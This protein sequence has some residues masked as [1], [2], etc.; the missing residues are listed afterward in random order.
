MSVP[1][2]ADRAV[3][4]NRRPRRASLLAS[5]SVA[6]L[7]TA[8]VPAQARDILRGNR[9]AAPVAAVTAQ[10]AAA[11]QQAR[12][13]SNALQRT[14]QAVQ[15]MR[16]A[17]NAARNLALRT[18]AAVPNG[19]TPDGLV[20]ALGAGAVPG[21][22]TGARLPTQ[23]QVDGRTQV[24]IKQTE[25]KAILNWTTFNV[26]RET[27]VRFDQ[28]GNSTW[29]ALN[30]VSDPA[31]RPSRIAGQIKA[32]GHVYI[33]NRNGVIFTGS[34][35]VNTHALIASSAG[36]TD[37]Q[38]RTAGIYSAQAA[39]AYVPS[40]RGAAGLVR[41][42]AGAEITTHTPTS[43]TSGG[44]FV[45]L[46]GIGVENA[47][48]IAT[49]KG[50]ALLAAG[51]DFILRRGYGTDANQSS[52]TR[53]SEVAPIIG[54]GSTSGT[55]VNAGL[56]FS[57]QGDITLVGRSVTQAG[58]ALATTSVNTRGTIHLLNAASDTQGSVVLATGSL[59]AILPELDSVETALDSQRSALIT[60]S[61]ASAHQPVAHAQFTNLSLLPDRLDQSRVEIVSG[62][63]VVFQRG[64]ITQAQGGQV[65]VSAARRV[66]AVDGALIDVSGTRDVLLPMSSNN[67]K[68]SIQGNELRDAPINRDSGHL[69]SSDVWIDTR[70]L[71]LVPAGTGG[72]ASER[73]Y[74]R[75]GLLEVRGYLNN[76]GHR[77]GEW[78]ALGGTIALSAREVVAQQG[79]IFDVSGGAV[80]YDGGYIRTTNLLG[81]DGRVYSVNGAPADQLFYG[82]GQGFVRKH[83]RWGVTEIWMN[84]LGKGRESLRWEAGYTIG[85]DAGGLILSA[86]TTIFD[87]TIVA[88]V[89][90]G[91][92]QA[93]ARP[94]GVTDGY[95]L[96]Q[97]TAPRAGSLTVGRYG[98]LGVEGGH[99]SKIVVGAVAPLVSAIGAATPLPSARTN[100]VLL[101]ARRLNDSA[102][103]GL[104]LT[105]TQ[106]V[107]IDA[108]L[109]LADGGSL[110]ITA[111]VTTIGADITAHSGRVSI[112]NILKVP[113]R[114]PGE[115]TPQALT[116]DGA[117]GVTLKAGTA[118][119]VRGVWT[120]AVLDPT[121]RIG[122]AYVD[123][124]T[125]SVATTGSVTIER[126]SLID[127]SSGAAWLE[128]GKLLG[129]RGGDVTLQVGVP[130][131]DVITG[132][133]L[134]LDG[135]LR[136]AGVAGGGTLSLQSP[137]TVLIGKDAVLAGGVLRANERA[138]TGVV[139]AQDLAI[140]PGG[141]I[142]VTVTEMRSTTPLE[143][144]LPA[145]TTPTNQEV[146]VT[147]STWT[148][149]PGVM[150]ATS[151][152]RYYGAGAVLPAGTR[153]AAF[154]GGLPFGMVVPAAVFPRGIPVRPFQFTLV[155]GSRTYEGYTYRPGQKVPQGTAFT[156][157]VRFA[158]PFAVD[159]GLFQTGFSTYSLTSLTGL[160]IGDGARID[161]AM[162]VLRATDTAFAAPT[163]STPAQVLAQWL[164]P[165][166]RDDPVTGRLTQRA[167]ANLILAGMDLRVDRGAAVTVD[168]GRSVR[169][170]TIR[171]ITVDGA[172]VAPGG[173]VTIVNDKVFN[174]EPGMNAPGQSI[175][176]GATA[177]LDVSAQAVTARDANGR[178]YGIVTEGG[179]IRIGIDSGQRPT[180][181]L[182]IIRDGA[183][184]DAS[185]TAVDL[186][187]PAGR[188]DAGASVTRAS[189][190]GT[191][192]IGSSAGLLLD[193][194]MRAAAG[195]QGAAGG[196]LEL[197]LET[198]YVS[199]TF[200]GAARGPHV[201]TITQER[202]GRTQPDGLVAGVHDPALPYGQ[203]R[204]SVEQ[205]RAGGFD[206]LSLW[207]RDI[208]R[209]DGD[210]DLAMGRS[211]ILQRGILSVAP[212]TPAARVS[213][214]APH[215]VLAGQGNIELPDDPT[216]YYA[217]IT[218]TGYG[219]LM[220][221][222]NAG[223]L[224]V[225]ADLIDLR[226]AV[227]FGALAQHGI[228]PVHN[229]PIDLPG[230]AD[231]ALISRG[232]VRIGNGSVDAGRRLT[233]TAAQLYPTTGAKATIRA[234][235]YK[236]D[237]VYDI[238]FDPNAVI[239]IRGLGDAPPP[240][241]AS[242]FGSLQLMAATMEQGGI[243]R[244]PLGTIVL[245]EGVSKADPR[246]A[247]QMAATLL[248]GSV[249][250][251]SAAGL[252][253]PYGG[254]VDGL[255]YTY[256]GEKVAFSDL[257]ALVGDNGVNQGITLGVGRIDIDR[258]ALLD[259][260][261]GGELSGAAFFTGRGGS[262][263]VLRT[264]LAN[265]N[266]A[267][268]RGSTPG[269]RVYAI[270]PG[271][272]SAYA[273]LA[274]ETGAGDPVVGQQVTL[275]R[276]VG[277]LP[278]GTYTLLPSTY[279]LLPGA[280][281]VEIGGAAP[282]DATAR[283]ADGSHVAAGVLSVANTA[284][285][286]VL[287]TLLTL[288][289][290]SIVRTHSQY[291]ETS[292][293]AF[294]LANAATFNAV[295]PRLPVDGK[296][297][298][299]SFGAA[300]GETLRF[301][302]QALF[303]PARGGYGGT[304][305]VIANTGIEVKAAGA[306]A[307]P[308]LVSL[309]AQDL[310]AF[311][312]SALLIGGVYRYEL[313]FD[314]STSTALGPRVI[315]NGN[316]AGVAVRQGA[317][318][319]GGQIFVVGRDIVI[320]RGATLD[321]SAGSSNGIDSSLGYVF[322][323]SLD[324]RNSQA[325]A[326]LTVANGYFHFLPPI[327]DARPSTIKVQDGAILRT[328][329]TIA[330]S[331]AGAVDP[332]QAALNAR[333]L[334][335][336]LPELNI[337]DAASFAA[338]EA[339]GA[340]GSGWR[341]TQSMIARLL[342]PTASGMTPVERLTFTVGGSINIFGGVT[343]DMRSTG[344]TRTAL[345]LN[346]PA[347][348]GWGRP[349]EVATIATDTLIWSGLVQGM[350]TVDK[351]YVSVGP[352]AVRP[353]G[354]GTGSGALVVDA[355]QIV[356]GYDPSARPQ[357]QATLDRLMLGF[358]AVS[359]QA[360]ERISANNRSSLA[361]YHT[362]ASA[363]TY[364]GGSLALRTPLLTGEAGSFMTYRSGGAVTVSA[365]AGAASVDTATITAL[366]GEVR[367]AGTRVTLDTAVALPSG[368]LMLEAASDIA[369]H[370]RAVIDLS[371]R[372]VRFFDVTRY[373]WGG[374]L[375]MES[376][377]GAIRQAAGSTI[378]VSARNND[379]GRIKVTATGADGSVALAGRL[380][381]AAD[382]GF[383]AGV[384]DIRARV[385]DDFA[386]L[387]GRL[388]QGEVFGA[389]SFVIKTGDLVVGDD[390]R[391]RRVTI[392]VD[393]GSLT[394]NG[395]IDASGRGAGII[396]LAARDNLVL[397]TG[398]MLDAHGTV[399]RVDS[400]GAPI[401][402]ANTAQIE[403]TTTHG[404]L[405][406]AR[407][408]VIDLRAADGVARGRLELNAPRTVAAG[409]DSDIAISAAGPL[410]IS[411]AASIAINGWRR[412]AADGGLVD[413]VLLDRI[414]GDSTTFIDAAR[415]NDALRARLAGLDAH[416]LHLRPGVEI[417]SASA[418][419]DL[420]I[421]GD[422][423][424][425]GYRYGPDADPA[426]RGSGEPGVVVIRAGGRL[427]VNGSINDGFAPPP[428]TPDD[429]GWADGR[430][431][432]I[433]AI[434][435]M[436][437]P[438]SLSWSMR[439]VAGADTASADTR[440][441]RPRSSLAGGGDLV[442]SDEH[443]SG[444]FPDRRVFSV[445][446]T[447]T[448]TLD[449]LAGGD[450]R[451]DSLFGVY[452]AGTAIA[453]G[454]EHNL[455]LAPGYDG[456]VLGYPDYEA[457]LSGTRMWFTTGGGDVLLSAQGRVSS[458][459]VS[460]IDMS[461]STHDIGDWLWRQGGAD[462]GQPTAWG[463]NFGS[464]VA[465]N[466]LGVIKVAG[467]A[468][469]GA[470]GGGNVTVEAGGDAGLINP[471]SRGGFDLFTDALNIA[472][473][474]SG[475]V[476][477]DGTLAQTGGGDL[478]L[479][480]GGRLNPTMVT[481]SLFQGLVTNV[482]G[483]IRVLA[484]SI[485][486]TELKQ[487]GVPRMDD[488]RPVDNQAPFV[489]N[490]YSGLAVAP[491][492][493]RATLSARGDL[494]MFIAADP[495][496]VTAR[497]APVASDGAQTAAGTSWFTLWTGTTAIDLFSAGGYVS[498]M[499]TF[500]GTFYPPNLSVV[501]AGGSI[502]FSPNMM[503][504]MPA[505]RGSLELLARDAIDGYGAV[506]TS[507]PSYISVSGGSPDDLAT[508]LRP[509]W[510]LVDSGGTV[511]ATNH[512]A[513]VNGPR[514]DSAGFYWYGGYY[515]NVAFV[516]G[517]FTA[518]AV[519][520][521]AGDPDPI[522]I[523]ALTGDISNLEIGNIR[524]DY[525]G[526]AY[527]ASYNA[528]KPVWLRAGRDILNLTALILNNDNDDISL[529]AAGRD[530]V[531][532]GINIAGPGLLEV[533]AG[534][535]IYQARGTINS[536]GPVITGD[537]RDGA[538]ITLLAG[539]GVNG[540]AYARFA[541][542]YL[543]PANRADPLRPLADQDGKVAKTYQ[544]E[545]VAWLAERFG[546]DGG[547]A[548]ALAYFQHLPV[549]QQAVFVR[550]VYFEELRQGGREYND[551]DSRRFGSYLRGRQAIATLL[552]DTDAAGARIDYSG[553][554]TLIGN[555]GVHT[556]FGGGIQAFTP[557]GG[558]LLGANGVAPPPSTGLLTQG[559]G[560]IEIYSRDSVLL[561]L[562]RI[563]TTFGGDIVI[564]SAVGDINAGRGAKTTVVYAPTKRVYDNYGNV[565]LSPQVPSTGAGI[566]TL[567][568]I[569]E[570]PAGD[571]DLIAPLGTID[572]GEAGIRVSG[573]I[574]LAALHILNAANIQVQGS[575]TGVPKAPPPNVGAMLS[576]ST[577][578]GAAAATTDPSRQARQAPRDLP[579]IITVE[580]LGY[581]GGQGGGDTQRRDDAPPRPGG[582]QQG[583]DAQGMFRV[584]GNGTFTGEQVRELTDEERRK[585]H[586]QVGQNAPL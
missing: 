183:R 318:L 330:F 25:A 559:S 261:G 223:H 13:A 411:G 575:I 376:T 271:Y 274:P 116:L 321:T 475:R 322:S 240:L 502:I 378:D 458:Y 300:K 345:I 418:G 562:S 124:G 580:V 582:S 134:T 79:A 347:L 153:I 104:H 451:Q 374:E 316:D 450:Y 466:L 83:A 109:T 467:F 498:P 86:P 40:F 296:T 536:I 441:L 323:D 436:L 182:V 429:H 19:L 233:I 235:V 201:F 370:D 579:S 379:A 527:V 555:A 5:V 497:G 287:P 506:T 69:K 130:A 291:N 78:A 35:Q 511:L 427:L 360:S 584:L 190:G 221:T 504:L 549:E 537:R 128:I 189:A 14:T 478:T 27:T 158:P 29:V 550:Q 234:G 120:N 437:A 338:A 260:S 389:R 416:G 585:L 343:I 165:V 107:A 248:P 364:G 544:A 102:L 305:A 492:D 203:A 284:I 377:D 74:T 350:G 406:L 479:R 568:P 51:D 48:T 516:H 208:F 348:Y 247:Q 530:I 219:W 138:P 509:G 372:G 380:R 156:E 82:L 576:A 297:L 242:V 20:V 18:P 285:R 286:D 105:T 459:A 512:Y 570:V 435:P 205:V 391:A 32:D 33:I 54:A 337:G 384:V 17:Q 230:F 160:V 525:V 477:A 445:I 253:V 80:S 543:D 514:E 483:D 188:M 426:R 472:V 558:I 90:A 155:A 141:I 518:S 57:Q 227:H 507:G 135:T 484:G 211:L 193:G 61:S 487:Y 170:A 319:R 529:I 440:T 66:L 218:Y 126:G 52:T 447:G 257:A 425:S 256:N 177:V 222:V 307:T 95:A 206:T 174:R 428:A 204:L 60:A 202:I 136:A 306:P 37:E 535:D 355:R 563:M 209:F 393:G 21:V 480:V 457:A 385:L 150:L 367:L 476:S 496:R 488:P 471:I 552:P 381:G 1:A 178:R 453:V 50:Q 231:V 100:T 363:S 217:G 118:I 172:I 328:Q 212:T 564:W 62:G 278:A 368:R 112:T 482:R 329:G 225:T 283:L 99:D 541:A 173:S 220:P 521:H 250:S 523:Y 216:L 58:V 96:P 180:G 268:N 310:S 464:Y 407:G 566:A 184:L 28:Q 144:P 110:S 199:N 362:G 196:R 39:G 495:G 115:F 340:I 259:L 12:Q 299:L 9:T 175:W 181:A 210:V 91:Q 213:L 508:P 309:N 64:S 88:G 10:Q 23:T 119:D 513:G 132:A 145:T 366:G 388:N 320:E 59:S 469:I 137:V 461:E 81:S 280:W 289:P 565:T 571:I 162:P 298:V 187:L 281:R 200:L 438:G 392:A 76:S 433:W 111:P 140:L 101:D 419:G 474:G 159:P 131:H 410:D 561:G 422:L 73:Y 75:G 270:V 390:V 505:A 31:A 224:T 63:D 382:T 22:W 542:R 163:G 503:N 215:V 169:L 439:L 241:P 98:T 423:D 556:D 276:A 38:F 55:V 431:G 245:G 186:D 301:D 446:R 236:P 264:A 493:G 266:P 149:P 72:Y 515:G 282:V 65:A 315:F 42:E 123:G 460:N 444:Y 554:I 114:N 267:A 586:Q 263:D 387:N 44:G 524:Q 531:N 442:L 443:F 15:A 357:T 463:I 335:L 185:G 151:D 473:G 238:A 239:A 164:P 295:R 517:P 89:V 246:Y 375:V 293:S 36:I 77:I 401:D 361:V 93:T 454:P 332:G 195:G 255:S 540:P 489:A 254:T 434:A 258:G 67:L 397:G 481:I 243:V 369:L 53:G 303:A 408:A 510:N 412:Y 365:P 252:I 344:A 349:G 430:A 2:A 448:G 26:G 265:A 194:D 405:T 7:V 228:A 207:S 420:T 346:T 70:D 486:Q 519:N 30:R 157:A 336:S 46:L 47:G 122:L 161:V 583:Y 545:L 371:G 133:T 288:T 403:L 577:T 152:G 292:Y 415:G 494:S 237:A 470:L 413:Q 308:G 485:G 304:L 526:G 455:P 146:I 528:A 533:R 262:V 167:G 456:T 142:P 341:L 500:Y 532:A 414:H 49:P 352:G 468:G 269:A 574:N 171:Q 569:P 113:G 534:S 538:G 383:E 139:L 8:S 43:V 313:A 272:A 399:L 71:V 68:V 214:A 548:G 424:F 331:A 192:A 342:H 11:M 539:V 84:P 465:D 232:D 4:L 572:A 198:T 290:A 400:R 325:G 333:F 275:S 34:A 45:A 244:A 226:D 251:V 334:T 191:I 452:T 491:G 402:A 197:T 94:G 87:G 129:G 324:D 302:G 41:V 273:P 520:V 386:G 395:R 560:D 168:P 499:Q 326:I 417:L 553:T 547:A 490:M 567:A 356:F 148:L 421:A 327:L 351:P 557:G 501:A 462:L 373:S 398:G 92:R 573:S 314:W 3:V 339:A 97:N 166:Y 229:R 108:P 354:A 143:T 56:I 16:A 353:G 249:T 578:A 6:A 359:L 117:A 449:L 546:Y 121:R 409:I 312:A 581:G 358:S 179:A 317:T 404:T 85:R 106:T 396:R 279:A 154:M 127:V 394:I 125:V 103:G 432:R 551:P 176:I 522:R 147:A 294:A 277:G 24:D 311:N